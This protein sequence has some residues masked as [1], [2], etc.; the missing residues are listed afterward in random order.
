[1]VE[2]LEEEK[3]II[4]VGKNWRNRNAPGRFEILLITFFA[5]FTFLG[6]KVIKFPGKYLMTF[7][8]SHF[9]SYTAFTLQN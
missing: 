9:Y 3:N 7:F 4:L 5:Y 8:A 1:V 2:H 6:R